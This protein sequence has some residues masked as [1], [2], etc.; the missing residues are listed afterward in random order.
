M[1]F[2]PM[3]DKK[4]KTLD[5]QVKETSERIR[6]HVGDRLDMSS[7]EEDLKLYEVVMDDV[8]DCIAEMQERDTSRHRRAFVRAAVSAVEAFTFLLKKDVLDN[9]EQESPMAAH[10]YS[11]GE[12]AILR[13]ESFEL[14][15]TKVESKPRFIPLADNLVFALTMYHWQFNPNFKLD[16]GV[17]EYECFRNA[18][19]IRNRITHP[20][21]A[22]AMELSEEEIETVTRAFNWVS[23]LYMEGLTA[24]TEH[25]TKVME[26]SVAEYLQEV[27]VKPEDEKE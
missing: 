25:A 5:E 23:Q 16:R 17:T 24:F 21:E 3:T 8:T 4:D 19:N 18:I 10:V 26:E 7:M 27:G 12:M 2:T 22:S 6:K 1:S 11:P 15:R 20:R 14:R 13:E 9:I